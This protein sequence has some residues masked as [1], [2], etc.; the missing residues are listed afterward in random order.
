[1]LNIFFFSFRIYLNAEHVACWN[2]FVVAQNVRGSVTK[3]MTASKYCVP[4]LI[5]KPIFCGFLCLTDT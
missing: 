3:D 2:H 5:I 1:M 4:F